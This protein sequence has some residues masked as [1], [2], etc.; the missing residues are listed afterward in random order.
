MDAKKHVGIYEVRE[1][2]PQNRAKIGE[3]HEKINTMANK[4]NANST[5]C[6]YIEIRC[7]VPKIPHHS[8][9][10]SSRLATLLALLALSL[11]KSP[12]SPTLRRPPGA[13]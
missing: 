9:A 2:P 7:P 1:E 4:I 11:S 5:I 10:D 3:Y 12:R 6:R 13:G 8:T